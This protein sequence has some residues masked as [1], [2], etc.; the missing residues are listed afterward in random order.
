[1]DTSVSDRHPSNLLYCSYTIPQS[2]AFPNQFLN[3][4]EDCGPYPTEKLIKSVY[5]TDN[6]HLTK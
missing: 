3:E 6:N 5:H 2:G 4:Q 1:M